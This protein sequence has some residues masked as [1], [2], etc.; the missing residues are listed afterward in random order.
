[1]EPRC[2]MAR[3]RELPNVTNCIAV[4]IRSMA[5][6][7]KVNLQPAN[8]F[9]A[10]LLEKNDDWMDQ[11][12]TRLTDPVYITFDLDAFDSSL[13]PSTGTPE[14]GGLQWNQASQTTDGVAGNDRATRAELLCPRQCSQ[15]GCMGWSQQ[16]ACC[17][18]L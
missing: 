11:V 15:F 13:M 10:H 2:V 6:E 3:V 4:G 14:P 9:F 7:E 16:A 12:L 8:T 1:M 18:L 17:G 5:I